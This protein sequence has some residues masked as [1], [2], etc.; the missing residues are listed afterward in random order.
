MKA[1]L[2]QRVRAECLRRTAE[3][4][5]TS[6]IEE[7]KPGL[8]AS[9]RATVGIMRDHHLPQPRRFTVHG[10]TFLAEADAHQ[11]GAW[12]LTWESGPHE[13]YGFTVRRS[14]HTWDTGALPDL[15][16]DFLSQ[17]DPKTGHLKD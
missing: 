8:R 14:D 12:H 6:T 4:R 7:L 10:E 16:R 13:G 3:D 9:A 5:P 11:P 15:A 2:P 1:I 17:I